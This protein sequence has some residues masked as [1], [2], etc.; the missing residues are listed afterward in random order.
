MGLGLGPI[1]LLIS[2]ATTSECENG[3]FFFPQLSVLALLVFGSTKAAIHPSSQ[4]RP[5]TC[6]SQISFLKIWNC[7]LN[8]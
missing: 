2:N 4:D 1:I 8:K 3:A 7:M 5:L 6:C